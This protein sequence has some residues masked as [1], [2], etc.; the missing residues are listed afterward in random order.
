VGADAVPNLSLPHIILSSVDNLIGAGGVVQTS[1]DNITIYNLAVKMRLRGGVLPHDELLGP[2]LR[3]LSSYSS[4]DIEANQTGHW[5]RLIPVSNNFTVIGTNTTGTYVERTM[6]VAN[7]LYSG[8][9]RIVYKAT[10]AGPLKYDLAF[11]AGDAGRYRLTYTWR[12]V[13]GIH[14]LS[15]PSKRFTVGYGLSNYTLSWG[16]V[17]PSLNATTDITQDRFSLIIDLGPM[18]VG[19]Q[20]K[21]DPSVVSSGQPTATSY[22]FQRKVFYEPKGGNYFVFY[23]NGLSTVYRSSHDG[24]SNSW[25]APQPMPQGWPAYNDTPSSSP[26]VWN[27]GQIVAVAA[28]S[29]I[30]TTTACPTAPCRGLSTVSLY[31]AWGNIIGPN[32]NWTVNPATGTQVFTPVPLARWCS[33][34]GAAS[35]TLTLGIRHVSLAVAPDGTPAFSFNFYA[36]GPIISGEGDGICQRDSSI[37]SDVAVAYKGGIGFAGCESDLTPLRSTIFLADSQGDLRIVYQD[38]SG[39]TMQLKTRSVGGTQ[40]DTNQLSTVADTYITASSTSYND[41]FGTLS[42]LHLAA[43]EPGTSFESDALVQFQPLPQGILLKNANLI[44]TVNQTGQGIDNFYAAEPSSPWDEYRTTWNT[45]WASGQG[46]LRGSVSATP[47]MTLT[48]LA[49]NQQFVLDVSSQLKGVTFGS[50]SDHGL[51]VGMGSSIAYLPPTLNLDSRESGSSVSP[52]LSASY[53]CCIGPPEVLETNEDSGGQFSVAVDANYGAHVVFQSGTNGNVSYAYRPADGSSWAFTPTLFAFSMSDPAVTVDYSTNDIYVFVV[54][55]PFANA[56]SVILMKHKGLLQNW[57]DV[58]AV[59]AASP[60]YPIELGSNMQSISGTNSSWVSIIWTNSQSPYNLYFES[61]PIQ[62]VW[63]PFASPSDPWDGYGI[64]PYAQY[65]Q[66]LGEYVSTSTG[67]LSIRQTALSLPGRGVNLD[68]TLVYTEPYIFFNG[69]PDNFEP[70][71][72]APLGNGWQL[73][74]PW[75]S[76]TNGPRHIHLWDGEGYSIPS[77]FWSGNSGSF[78]THQGEQ[79]RMVRNTTDVVLYAKSGESFRFDPSSH[80]LTR[81]MDLSGNNITFTYSNNQISTI[82]D[83]VGRTFL[84]CYTNNQL[85]RID[86]A[87]GG[88]NSEALLQRIGFVYSSSGFNVTDPAGRTTSYQYLT[89]SSRMLISRTTYPTKWYTSYAYSPT[90][91]GTDG[92]TYRITNQTVVTSLG[93]IVKQFLYV[94]ND[95]PSGQVNSSTVT[96]Y[97]GTQPFSYSDYAFSFAGVTW[98]V[99]DAG[100]H[101]VRGAQEVFG[102]GG[103]VVKET[104]LVAGSGLLGSYTNYYSYDLWGNL[105]Y[106]RRTITSNSY[107]ESFNAYYNGGVLPGFN[108]FQES[109]SQNQGNSPDNLWAI[110][111]GNWMAENGVYNETSNPGAQTG[112]FVW[113][114]IGVTNVTVQASVVLTSPVSALDQRIGLFTHYDATAGHKWALVIHSFGSTPYLELLDDPVAGPSDLGWLGNSQNS[115]RAY[116]PLNYGVPYNFTLATRGYAA[117]GTAT[118]PGQTSPCNVRGTFSSSRPAL[119]TKS[120]LYSLG[121]NALYDNFTATTLNPFMK[122][123]SFSNSFGRGRAPGGNLHTALAGT[124]EFQNGTNSAPIETY[125]SYNTWGGLTQTQRLSPATGQ[126][127][128]TSRTY[129]PYENPSQVTDARGNVTLYGYSPNYRSAFLTSEDQTLVPGSTLISRRY[130]YDLTM[131]TMLSSVDPNGYNTSYTYDILGRMTSIRYQ[132]GDYATYAYNDPANLVNMTNENGWRTQQR[133]DG[134][135]RLSAVER[136][137]NNSPYSFE[138]YT[139][140]LQDKTVTETDP[141]GN[142]VNYQ[143]DAL[144]RTTLVTKPDLNTTSLAYDDLDSWVRATDE[145]GVSKCS[146][147][148]RAGRL[149]SIVENADFLCRGI[150]TSYYYDES[151]NLRRLVPSN[152]NYF[153]NPGFEMG[154]FS[155]WTETGLVISDAFYSGQRHSGRFSAQAPNNFNGCSPDAFTLQQNFPFPIPASQVKTLGFWYYGG[156]FPTP[157][158]AKVLYSDG[159]Y[160]QTSLPAN[161]AWTFISLSLDRSK[162]ITGVLVFRPV[163]TCYSI[164]L[165]DFVLSLS[166]ST[167]YS[168]DNLNRLTRTGYPDGTSEIYG[169][170]NSGNLVQKTDRNIV[171]TSYSYDS[172]NRPLTI[173]Y[174]GP[175]VTTDQYSYDHNGNLLQLQ[176]QNAT[177]TY[178]YDSRNRVVCETYFINGAAISGGPCGNGGGGGS[179][180]AGTLITLADRTQVPVQNLHVGDSLLSYNITTGTYVVSTIT[181]LVA[182]ETTNMLVIKTMDPLPLMVDNATA[183]KLWVRQADGTTSWLSVTML[184]IGDSL[185]NAFDQQWTLVTSIQNAPNG[186]HMMFDI[187]TTK[188]YDYIANGYLDPPKTP[189]SPKPGPTLVSPSSTPGGVY[190]AGYTFAYRYSGETLQSLTYNDFMAANYFYDD[191]GRILN[192]TVPN[193]TASASFSYYTND[194]VKGI[195]Y[196]NG[197]MLNYTYD[198]DSRPVTVKLSTPSLLSLSYRYNKTG[199]VASV[200]GTVNSVSVSEQY[201]Y[202]PLGR[203]TNATLASGSGKTASTTSLWYQYDNLGNRVWQGLNS[204][205]TGYKWTTTSYGYNPANNELTNATNTGTATRYGYDSDGN[206]RTNNVTSGGTTTHWTYTWDVRGDLLK[207]A[208][209]GG[210]QGYYAYDG[211]G[212]RVEA[213]EA[214][215]ILFYAYAGTETLGEH[216]TGGADTDYVYANGQRLA[217]ITSYS[218]GSPAVDYYHND[219]LGSTRL[220]TSSP[221]VSSSKSVL[222]SDSYQPYGQDNVASGTETYKFTGKPYSSA[223]GL[224]YD[225]VRWYD[226]SIGRFISADRV[227]G[228][229]RDPQSLNPYVYVENSPTNSVDPSG[230]DCL[231]SLS[232]F[233]GCAGGFLYDNTAGAAVNSYNWYQGASDSDRWAFWTG[234]GVAVG[235][236]VV[237]GASCV[238]AACAGLALLGIGALTGVAGSVWA[239]DAYRLAGGQ[240]EGGLKASLFWGGIGAGLGFAGGSAGMTSLWNRGLVRP[241]VSAEMNLGSSAARFRI[242]TSEAGWYSDVS[243]DTIGATEQE[244][245]HLT[246]SFTGNLYRYTAQFAPDVRGVVGPQGLGGASQ[247]LVNSGSINILSMSRYSLAPAYVAPIVAA[248]GIF[249]AAVPL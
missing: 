85:A 188:P 3:A 95:A 192:V 46:V 128:V 97:N 1:P 112:S 140:N 86:Q 78:E 247:F 208:N 228:Y 8:E 32:I 176:S 232:D 249:T 117:N 132:T 40:I 202:D 144:G 136:F 148:D 36:N 152:T 67:L 169:Y 21:V 105:I 212:R 179:V 66:N 164:F 37:E 56:A 58:S 61:I 120:G 143:Y 206:L 52:K 89:Q 238:V 20:V 237:I 222:F 231:S 160:A 23:Y 135:G 159:T 214:S 180:A 71:P 123:L 70:Y 236:G 230:L 229:R 87:S 201:R 220:V 84:F 124:A 88:C 244:F 165:D 119:A 163:A 10:S 12:N 182:V 217:K 219:A 151:G 194:Q 127:L 209:D 99:S 175:T 172:L 50:W 235:I 45:F 134:L 162:Q 139:Y 218:T 241:P 104:I 133:Y 94:Y 141:V 234:V 174:H 31:Y 156:S 11:T 48:N 168:Y 54:W 200:T 34:S 35:C 248:A 216:T 98:N 49:K 240:S 109:F 233:G 146:V 83:T 106:S 207:A 92:Q 90:S 9:L 129:D 131:G 103:Q 243:F 41:N 186:L 38:H 189:Q 173:T 150:V 185:F 18:S 137:R 15:T 110:G 205:A 13:T 4:W 184:R 125:Y 63:S 227:A 183:Q 22:T 197:L 91:V 57:N 39:S 60:Y 211:L 27:Q 2:G 157:D 193:T 64:A 223:T 199:T 171:Q 126:W 51:F 53:V 102:V 81:I 76:A 203:L 198:S 25:S 100:H 142:R 158:A 5:T 210:V 114:D 245:G 213:K 26:F 7:P 28:G 187:Y 44:F 69:Q 55:T 30:Q 68:I 79:F 246:R 147:F 29:T 190:G 6:N 226:P 181:S 82:T 191:L 145:N 47:N 43:P 16:D 155:G 80:A 130:S 33:N 101:L 17:P 108:V 116:C 121:Y 161:S 242:G 215:S 19:S 93:S 74:F 177:L 138:T 224:Y 221:Y 62:T 239:A 115:A 42:Y 204:T 75:M 73:N 178:T 149:V 170:D 111:Q 72:W 107:H 195:A 122:T 225:Y 14:S 154:S 65:F 118:F 196:G 96:A 24:T 167:S 113:S 153:A 59:P 166:Q 77:S